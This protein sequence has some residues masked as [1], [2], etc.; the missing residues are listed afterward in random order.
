M[1]MWIDTEF[2][3]AQGDL[4]SDIAGHSFLSSLTEPPRLSAAV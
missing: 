4:L 2:H 1:R 3:G